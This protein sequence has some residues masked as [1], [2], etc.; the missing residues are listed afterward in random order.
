MVDPDKMHEIGDCP[1]LGQDANKIVD[2]EAGD[3][4]VGIAAG[5]ENRRSCRQRRGKDPA[6]SIHQFC[7]SS[8]HDPGSYLT[9]CELGGDSVP[10]LSADDIEI[11]QTQGFEQTRA[12]IGGAFPSGPLRA[13]GRRVRPRC[14][15]MT[16]RRWSSMPFSEART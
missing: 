10:D 5:D 7:S 14:V 9:R 2:L 6:N 12:R 8:L 3:L 11:T 16:P 4:H 15:P 1:C 13:A